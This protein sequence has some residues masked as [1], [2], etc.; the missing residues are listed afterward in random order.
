MLPLLLTMLSIETPPLPR[1]SNSFISGSAAATALEA[2]TSLVT[3]LLAAEQLAVVTSVT[4]ATPAERISLG[5]GISLAMVMAMA[6]PAMAAVAGAP[7]ICRCMASNISLRF[8]TSSLRP[9][10]TCSDIGACCSGS[11]CSGTRAMFG[12]SALHLTRC[13]V[14]FQSFANVEPHGQ[15]ITLRSLPLTLFAH[16]SGLAWCRCKVCLV[17]NDFVHPTQTNPA[18]CAISLICTYP[19][20]QLAII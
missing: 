1:G 7:F 9:F 10:A 4:E 14:R 3:E 6:G 12:F 2:G 18:A 16:R 19:L 17:A 13:R 11:F 8:S 20:F 5:A 15:D